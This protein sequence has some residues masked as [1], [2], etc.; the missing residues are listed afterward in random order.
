MLMHKLKRLFTKALPLK[1][2]S[3]DA[4]DVAEVWM[5]KSGWYSSATQELAPGLK[6]TEADTVVDVGCGPGGAAVFAA[7]HGAKVVGVD[8]DAAELDR[9]KQRLQAELAE[10]PKRAIRKGLESLETIVSDCNPIPLS[11]DFATTVVA[12]EVLEHVDDPAK[13]L[14]ELVR[15]GKPG[16]RYLLS[17]PDP[18]SESIQRRIAPA[19]YW[20][21]PNHIRVFE[22]DEFQQVVEQAGLAVERRLYHGFYWSIWWSLF[23]AAPQN[24]IPFGKSGGCDILRNWNKTWKALITDPKAEHVWRALEDALPKSQVIIAR[25]AA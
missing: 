5:W 18:A 4:E 25:K 23:W 20:S 24:N 10:N 16:A 13:F 17:V 8:V 19:S 7:R 15:I 11:A 14:A 22:R 9:L 3:E 2:Y 12:M 6:I 1:A 21:K